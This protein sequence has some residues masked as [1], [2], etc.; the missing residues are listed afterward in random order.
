M[1]ADISWT[2]YDRYKVTALAVEYLGFF[3]GYSGE[4]EFSTAI[5]QL[6][7]P[8]VTGA[9]SG[10][11]SFVDPQ[12]GEVQ[13]QYDGEVLAGVTDLPGPVMEDDGDTSQL[14]WLRCRRV[15]FNYEAY[16]GTELFLAGQDTLW[17]APSVG[18]VGKASEEHDPFGTRTIRY[19]LGWAQPYSSISANT[20]PPVFK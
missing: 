8:V 20:P 12:A 9:W 2:A 5:I 4:V 7:L 6:P 11:S 14:H 16:A 17:Y 1:R 3:N 13:I 15:V 10:T 19:G 18:F